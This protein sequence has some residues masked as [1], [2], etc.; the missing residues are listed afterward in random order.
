MQQFMCI[1]LSE[2]SGDCSFSES[3]SVGLASVVGLRAD[4]RKGGKTQAISNLSSAL[5]FYIFIYIS[6]DRLWVG[7]SIVTSCGELGGAGRLQ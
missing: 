5:S 7:E 3:S 6:R 4:F 1:Y 2:V